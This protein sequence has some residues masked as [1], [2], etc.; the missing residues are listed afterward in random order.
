MH[1]C[2]EK[3]PTEMQNDAVRHYC[4]LLDKKKPSLFMKRLFDVI[5]SALM[6]LVL[7]LPFAV[8]AAFI[9][10]DSSGPVFFRQ[11]RLTRNMRRFRIF[12]FR[13]M[14]DKAESKGPLVT[15]ENDSRITRVGA[16]LRAKRI[17]E[18]PQL[19]N[20][21]IGDMSFVGTRP[22]VAKYVECYSEEMLATLLLPAG[23]TSRASIYFKDE[24]E[25]L[26]N[27]VDADRVY[28][29]EVLP[30]KMKYNLDYLNSFSFFGDIK[31][32]FETFFAVSKKG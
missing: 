5:V 30:Q 8:I 17:D 18:M 27:A 4:E 25:L 13:T 31:L 11:T 23:V 12:K 3:L 26:R 6:L 20:V 14:C 19:I 1:S 24:S 21:F 32:M 7:A 16:F 29:E 28:I 15:V 2:Y 10:C 9:K 22:E